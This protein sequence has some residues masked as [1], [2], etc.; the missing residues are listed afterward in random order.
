EAVIARSR[1]KHRCRRSGPP[2][3]SRTGPLG[4]THSTKAAPR[5]PVLAHRVACADPVEVVEGVVVIG[6]HPCGPSMFEPPHERDGPIHGAA[7]DAGR[8][9]EEGAQE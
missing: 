4:G 9:A 8:G 1:R 2:Y 6:A 7:P 3:G 5:Y